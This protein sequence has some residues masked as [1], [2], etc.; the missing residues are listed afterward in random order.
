MH[1][2]KQCKK[3]ARSWHHGKRGRGWRSCFQISFW[4]IAVL[5]PPPPLHCGHE[6]WWKSFLNELRHWILKCMHEFQEACSWTPCS[7]M[8]SWSAV[9]L[10]TSWP[11]H[12]RSNENFVFAT[13]ES[14]ALKWWNLMKNHMDT[15]FYWFFLKT[16]RFLW[17]GLP[18]NHVFLK[19]QQ[20]IPPHERCFGDSVGP[21]TKAPKKIFEK[22][23]S[24]K[25]RK[26]CTGPMDS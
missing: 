23:W 16:A 5:N 17:Q 12:V 13:D 2:I 18:Y 3:W 15:C 22:K 25:I 9:P 7:C 14:M 11:P 19:A 1:K 10:F 6:I 4:R 8:T 26:V 20:R 21:H 24:W